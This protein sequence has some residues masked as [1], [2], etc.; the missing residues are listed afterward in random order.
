MRIRQR[1]IMNICKFHVLGS[2]LN[3][4]RLSGGSQGIYGKS[5]SCLVLKNINPGDAGS[6]IPAG[7]LEESGEIWSSMQWI[8][9]LHKMVLDTSKGTFSRTEQALLNSKRFREL[10]TKGLMTT[11]GLQSLLQGLRERLLQGALQTPHTGISSRAQIRIGIRPHAP[12]PST[13]LRT[14]P[15]VPPMPP[16][17]KRRRPTAAGPAPPIGPP[18]HAPLRRPPSRPGPLLER[19]VFDRRRGPVNLLSALAVDQF[20]GRAVDQ[21]SGRA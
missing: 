7:M 21:L 19:P 6:D 4:L 17:R 18:A 1:K 20:S 10:Q 3:L 14:L 15:R 8:L 12:R 9:Q 16:A 13:S 2:N 5:S 11:E